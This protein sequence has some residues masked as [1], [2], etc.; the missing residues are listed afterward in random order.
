MARRPG[1]GG[2]ITLSPRERR[3]LGWIA[4]LFIV[5][6]IAVVVGLLGGNGDGTPVAPGQSAPP[7]TDGLRTIALGTTIDAST[8]EVA[9]GTRTD[10][11]TTGDTFA[12]SIRPSGELPAAIYV[13]VVRTGGGQP[14][15]V[16]TATPENEQPITP[17][18]PAIAFSVAADIL[19][20]EWGP[21]QYRMRIFTQPGGDAVAEGTFTLVGAVAPG[22]TAPSS[23]P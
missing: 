21:G 16:Q 1:E 23:P 19:L 7:S 2:R 6:G 18:R 17:G 3:L 13:E 12:Y 9:E 20:A 4:A 14:E 5:V 10:R 11:F 22:S 8:G 15:V